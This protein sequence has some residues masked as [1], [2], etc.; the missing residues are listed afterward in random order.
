MIVNLALEYLVPTRSE[1]LQ[2]KIVQFDAWRR[3][4]AAACGGELRLEPWWGARVESCI[5][6][7]NS[8]VGAR[9]S[10]N[11]MTN[12]TSATT[13]VALGMRI[14]NRKCDE[15]FFLESFNPK[16]LSV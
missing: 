2:H 15:Y 11:E 9:R 6:F 12:A 10:N 4:A 14:H 7:F 16:G 13:R 8:Y 1:E 5:G 3:D